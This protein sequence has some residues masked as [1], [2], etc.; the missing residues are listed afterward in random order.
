MA[1]WF[2]YGSYLVQSDNSAFDELHSPG[3]IAAHSGI[4]RCINCGDT[5]AANAGNPLPPQNHQQHETSKGPIMWK[6]LVWA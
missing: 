2:K 6:L 3:H 1:A 4:Y 5:I